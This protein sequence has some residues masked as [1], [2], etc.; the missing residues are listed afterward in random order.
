MQLPQPKTDGQRAYIEAIRGHDLT[1]CTGPAG[2]G[3]TFLA[4]AE[5]VHMVSNG[6]YEKLVIVRPAVEA[7]EKCGHLPGDLLEKLAPFAQPLKEAIREVQGDWKQRDKVRV[8]IEALG[9]LRGRTLL[10]SFVILDE[11]QNATV[12]QMKLFLTRFGEGSKFVVCGDP[13]QCDIPVHR[14]G[15][16]DS[17]ARLSG[18]SSMIASIELQAA[19]IVRHPLVAI[20]A[21]AYAA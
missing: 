16:L 2:S 6:E 1:Y 12:S 14:S 17:I 7:G 8:E 19:D 9:M 10:R 13:T 15:F 4:A 18:R 11:A 20:V 3:K 5:G 21:E